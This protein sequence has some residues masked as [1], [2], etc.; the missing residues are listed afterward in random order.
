MTLSNLKTHHVRQHADEST[1]KNFIFAASAGGS[2]GG[3]SAE[4]SPFRQVLE[5]LDKAIPSTDVAVITLLPRGS[6]QIAQPA[7]LPEP[8]VKGY[9]KEFHLEDRLTWQ[10]MLRGKPVALGDVFKGD[11]SARYV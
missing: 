7:R 2:G 4:A 5:T 10:A 11:E 8:L 3:R 9:A 1:N 6:L